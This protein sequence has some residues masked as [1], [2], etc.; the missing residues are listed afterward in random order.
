MKKAQTNTFK[1]SF[2]KYLIKK[3]DQKITTSK[4]FILYLHGILDFHSRCLKSSMIKKQVRLPWKQLQLPTRYRGCML[5]TGHTRRYDR[6][7]QAVTVNCKVL[8]EILE[9]GGGWS[10]VDV[11]FSLIPEKFSV[12]FKILPV[13][14]LVADG[15]RSLTIVRLSC[16]KS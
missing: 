8:Q 10:W 15:L 4:Y 13:T 5:Y 14:G 1:K 7:C 11:R 12:M 3:P 9:T 6:L 16:N 2:E